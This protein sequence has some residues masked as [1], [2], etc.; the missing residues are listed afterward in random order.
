VTEP[1]LVVAGGGAVGA[2]LAGALLRAGWPLEAVA[3]RTRARAE[4][5]CRAIGG[6][7]PLDLRALSDP[8]TPLGD[9]PAALV[10]AVPDQEIERTAAAL[11]GRPWPA[12][13]LALHVSGAVEV[14]ALAPLASAGLAC[15]GFHPLKSFLDLERD[16]AS[17]AG[18]VVAVEGA[19]AAVDLAGRLAG[20]LRARPFTLAP[21]ARAAWHAGASHACNHLVALTDQALDLMQR[22]GLARDAARAALLPLL[23]G[24]LDN[25][26]AHAPAHA[27]TGPVA[28]GDVPVV[29]R[30]LQALAEAPPDVAAA[31]RA[32]AR[33]ALALAVEGRALPPGAADAIRAALDAP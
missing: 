12:D 2:A 24:T 6:G 32:L 3:C 8:R 17:W 30:H 28:R 21:G 19:P 14:A 5:R 9:G 29:R 18:T 7:R 4:Q 20:R 31:Y 13:S 26:R 25:L 27:L 33:R 1:R 11:S 22:A 16:I 15:G 23:A 10:L